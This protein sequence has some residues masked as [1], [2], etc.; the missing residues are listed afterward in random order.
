MISIVVLVLLPTLFGTA[1]GCGWQ[2]KVA[3]FAFFCQLIIGLPL[4]LWLGLNQ[5]LGVKG[6]WMGYGAGV[7]LLAIVTF[8]VLIENDWQT[9]TEDSNKRIQKEKND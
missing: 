5:K 9:A 3:P 4:A 1:I 6:F 2:K 8:I 7:F